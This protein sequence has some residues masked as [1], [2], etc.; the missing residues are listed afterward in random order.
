LRYIFELFQ[1]VL[2][3]KSWWKST[4]LFATW[5]TYGVKK[6][7]YVYDE[8]HVALRKANEG[9]IESDLNT[10]DSDV[11]QSKSRQRRQKAS[12]S[13]VDSESG[14]TV[15]PQPHCSEKY[16]KAMKTLPKLLPSPTPPSS[17]SV[18]ATFV[19]LPIV[20]HRL[21]RTP[22]NDA[23]DEHDDISQ[24]PSDGTLIEEL[25]TLSQSFLCNTPNDHCNTPS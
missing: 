10:S 24:Y 1:D 11:E 15:S 19:V 21:L 4:L 14:D 25:N 16:T 5:A 3:R 12:Y 7:L 17:R 22:G 18:D 8:L 13:F 20:P 9:T 23:A 6:V 2:S